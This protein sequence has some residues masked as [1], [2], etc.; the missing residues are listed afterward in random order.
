LEQVKGNSELG[1]TIESA[2]AKC[3]GGLTKPQD[4]GTEK[5][6]MELAP[7][8]KNV[9]LQVK[10]P[11]VHSKFQKRLPPVSVAGK[12]EQLETVIR[13]KIMQRGQRCA[14]L[15]ASRPAQPSCSAANC[16]RRL[17]GEM[18]HQQQQRQRAGLPD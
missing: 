16:Q 17:S 11:V 6:K 12:R 4:D 13:D 15:Q 3:L 8:A 1:A 9:E 2:A 14:P 7:K 5:S 18:I 10:I